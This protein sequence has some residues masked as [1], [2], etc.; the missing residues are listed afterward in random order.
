LNEPLLQ[1]ARLWKGIELSSQVFF[2]LHFIVA[3]LELIN[4]LFERGNAILKIPCTCP[5]ERLFH[6]IDQP[7]SSLR[8]H[9]LAPLAHIRSQNAV[10]L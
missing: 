7:I 1:P 3:A 9:A 10:Q 4:Q 5:D 8:L 6:P 2:R